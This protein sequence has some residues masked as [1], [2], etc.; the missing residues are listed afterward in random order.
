M[1]HKKSR[2][3]LRTDRG[4]PSPTLLGLGSGTPASGVSLSMA[5]YRAETECLSTWSKSELK[6]L[7]GAIEKMRAMDIAQLRNSALC[8][9][10][11]YEPRSARFTRPP[12]MAD[13]LR[14]FE[15]R[16]GRGNTARMHGVFNESV[17]YLVWLDRR[18]EVF[19]G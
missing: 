14:M 16:V 6:C 19:P 10:H 12:E 5:Y 11:K 17:F 3:R 8:S 1:P 13:D 15:I 18:H 4:S 7:V 2:S 9:A